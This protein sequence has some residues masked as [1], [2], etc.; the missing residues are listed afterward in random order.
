MAG[1][2]FEDEETVT[3]CCFDEGMVEDDLTQR[4]LTLAA[5]MERKSL[6]VSKRSISSSSHDST[7]VID[8]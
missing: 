8:G 7:H 5:S 2:F 4:C 1:L 3:R 6:S